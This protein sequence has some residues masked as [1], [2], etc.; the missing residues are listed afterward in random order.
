[1]AL[2]FLLWPVV[3]LGQTHHECTSRPINPT[4]IHASLKSV[5]ERAGKRL[6]IDPDLAQAITQIESS[7]DPRAV[8]SKGAQGLMQLMPETSA[9]MHVADPLDPHQ[10]ILGGMQF[11]RV[12]AND[13]RFAGN[14]YM[15]LVAYNAG[16]NRAV[17]PEESYRY[18]DAVLA[19]YQ[20]LKAQHVRR[21]GLIEPTQ[22]LDRSF[23]GAIQCK[24]ATP[25]TRVAVAGGKI[26]PSRHY[27]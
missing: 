22:S 7:F 21:G 12:L 27:R 24:Q 4:A 11:L 26:Q 13:R 8:S 25:A 19:V 6:R 18:A 9:A 5:Y 10:S 15:V 14:P 23:L 2:A 20:Q 1:M 16:P 17:F 3:A